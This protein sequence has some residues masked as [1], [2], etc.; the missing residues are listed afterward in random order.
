MSKNVK[1]S[2]GMPVYNGEQTIKA[3]LDALLHQ[4]FQEFELIISDNASTDATLAIC[5]DYASRDDRI[6]YIRQPK[7]LG[8]ARNFKYV[9]DEAEGDYFLWAAA[10]DI[11]SNDFLEVNLD[12]LENNSGY[13]ASTS[14]NIFEG[15][16]PKGKDLVTF[17]LD[18]ETPEQRVFQF[19]EHCWQSHCIF[20]SL[21]RT[22]VLKKCDLVGQH[23][24]ASD[25]AIDLFMALNGSINRT[26]KGLTT[27]GAKGIS[28]QRSSYKAFRNHPIELIAPF[29]KLSKIL[30]HW[31]K[32]FSLKDRMK[33]YK[34]LLSLNTTSLFNQIHSSLYYFI[35]QKLKRE[36]R[37]DL[38][39]VYK[40]LKS[41]LQNLLK[42]SNTPLEKMAEKQLVL[43]ALNM[44][45]TTR[46]I[47]QVNGLKEIEFCAFSQ[48]GEDGILDW[49]ASNIEG[50]APSFVE[51]GVGNYKESNTRLLLQLHNWKGLILDGS[52]EHIKNI[53]K[54][55]L[56]WR[57]DL[58]AKCA[59]IDKDNI[60][61]LIAV[62]G[63]SGDLGLLSVD[64]D[65][66]DYWVWK[67]IDIVKPMIVVSEYNAILG[68]KHQLTV[69]YK[70]E[71]QR[72]KAHHSLLYFGASLP[73]L[74]H[75]GKEKGYKFIGTAS[76]GCNA[77][78]VREDC[79]KS[80]EDKIKSVWVY[81]L[82]AREAR[83]IHGE[84]SFIS[85]ADRAQL[86]KD[87]EFV[88]VKNCSDKSHEFV[89]L[90]DLETL[91]S[92]EWKNGVGYKL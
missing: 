26:E 42:L 45:K 36:K 47:K 69:P 80:I 84:L 60:N 12:F 39:S 32:S 65:G 75:L 63:F 20:Y 35:Q 41:F 88:D 30:I 46:Q 71:F 34:F 28:N 22:D 16:D 64:I 10:D 48:W 72:S 81:P 57:H 58:Q 37:F 53:Q 23:F 38:M 18:A 19:F 91:Y 54:E 49:L 13:V 51:F 74:I 90:G 85:G 78:F 17:A 56:Y 24:I 33:I 83:D 27:L 3:A 92:A 73:A 31:S 1:I 61:Q 7:N 43:Q 40:K 11:R 29:Y 44:A 14:P 2:I 68:D 55:E 67:A 9:L 87:M 82:V 5:E 4:S 52:Q 86:I 15:Q 59:F 70:K 62:A 77:F 21:M 66:N 50:I 76:N 25:W 8:L 79:F 89:K 6:R